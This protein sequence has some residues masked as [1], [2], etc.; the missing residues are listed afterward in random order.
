[1]HGGVKP[2]SLLV[3]AE[4]EILRSEERRSS[5]KKPTAPAWKQIRDRQIGQKGHGKASNFTQKPAKGLKRSK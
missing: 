4:D 5:G 2:D 1:M 3:K